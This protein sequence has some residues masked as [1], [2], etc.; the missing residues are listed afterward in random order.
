MELG[1]GLFTTE[2]DC[3]TVFV[4]YGAVYIKIERYLASSYHRVVNVT[5]EVTQF[6]VRS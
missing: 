3:T 1:V 5:Y 2:S 6:S 4:F